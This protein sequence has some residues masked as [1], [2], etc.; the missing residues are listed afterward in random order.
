LV[1]SDIHPALAI[2]RGYH[3]H[4]APRGNAVLNHPVLDSDRGYLL[5]R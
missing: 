1:R 4:L 5:R 3:L 2:K